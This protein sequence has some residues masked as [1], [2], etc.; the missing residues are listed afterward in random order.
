MGLF[1]GIVLIVIG[2]RT[3]GVGA[4]IVAVAILQTG[5]AVNGTQAPNNQEP[6]LRIVTVSL[7]TLNSR[8]PEAAVSLLR[9]NADIIAVQEANNPAA[10]AREFRSRSNRPWYFITQGTTMVI[11]RW[12]GNAESTNMNFFKVS[13]KLDDTHS[14]KFWN[15][16]APKDYKH[17]ANNSRFFSALRLDIIDQKP[18][19]VAGDF[20]SSP[21]NDGYR[22]V[23]RL[24]T[25]T[26]QEAG[27]G[28]GLTFP[29]NA[30]R[31]G[32][33]FP[34]TRIDHIF[35]SSQ[36]KSI[37]TYVGPKIPNADHFPVIADLV[38]NPPLDNGI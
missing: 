7:R 5:V 36:L 31:S 16:H 12:P 34:F 11:S 10:L 8:M 14:L 1:S 27:T 22:A 2:S 6:Q 20:N 29:T 33:F 3:L 30:R 26:F 18:D 4:L 13:L 28:A 9:L 35:I 24:M 38:A 25:N 23:A 37:R 17:P 15:I 19:V 32:I 21:W